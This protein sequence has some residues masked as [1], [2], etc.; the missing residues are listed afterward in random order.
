VLNAHGGPLPAFRGMNAAEWALFHGIRPSVT[1]HWMDEGIDTGPIL[2]E[3]PIPV[4]PWR[5][6]PAGRG[7]AT[8]VSVE[9]LLEAADGIA[10]GTL[11]A[12]PQD[13]AAGRQYF[14]M[15]EPLLDVVERWAR[16]GRAPASAAAGGRLQTTTKAGHE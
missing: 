10:A 9:A 5:H 1:V 3:R 2:F 6:I 14:V 11:T 8:R 7:V 15:A 4:E 13:P 16:A 12:T